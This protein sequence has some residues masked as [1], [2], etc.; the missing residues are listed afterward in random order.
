MKIVREIIEKHGGLDA[1]GAGQ[2]LRINNRP[3]IPLEI[4]GGGP[5][6]MNL[7]TIRVMYRGRRRGQHVTSASCWLAINKRQS[8]DYSLHP[9][10][11]KNDPGTFESFAVFGHQLD[12]STRSIAAVQPAFI[13]SVAAQEYVNAM[14]DLIVATGLID[15][16]AQW[17]G[18]ERHG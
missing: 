14:S 9:Y 2:V 15:C 18:I 6:P 16:P 3:S 12:E 5:G 4:E 1:F 7:E 13:L 17:I 10:Y 8:Q 11:F